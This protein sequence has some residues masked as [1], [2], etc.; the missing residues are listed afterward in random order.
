MLSL[1]FS[2]ILEFYFQPKS[3]ARCWDVSPG[4]TKDQNFFRR[5]YSDQCPGETWQK[6]WRTRAKLSSDCDFDLGQETSRKSV[7]ELLPILS[8]SKL[9]LEFAKCSDLSLAP[10]TWAGGHA[11]P[12]HHIHNI[13][14]LGFLL[15]WP[16][17]IFVVCWRR[18]DTCL[19]GTWW[20]ICLFFD[21][22]RCRIRPLQQALRRQRV[23]FV[24]TRSMSNCRNLKMP[25]P[26]PDLPAHGLVQLQTRKRTLHPLVYLEPRS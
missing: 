23:F 24:R 19:G 2:W 18:A 5:T 15:I 13:Q 10:G 7:Q 1:E 22:S 11:W 16:G 20:V 8:W 6:D 4:D 21:M 25:I 12:G 14:A 17:P 26:P 9:I 3:S